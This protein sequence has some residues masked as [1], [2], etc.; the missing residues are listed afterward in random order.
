M[1]SAPAEFDNPRAANQAVT[2]KVSLSS[3]TRA[4]P[5]TQILPCRG[6]DRPGGPPRPHTDRLA[7][8]RFNS[9]QRRNG[10]IFLRVRRSDQTRSPF[11]VHEPEGRSQRMHDLQDFLAP[12][13]PR[14]LQP[15]RDIA[16]P[17]PM[18]AHAGAIGKKRKKVRK[19]RRRSAYFV[20]FGRGL[21][22][23]GVHLFAEERLRLHTGDH[24]EHADGVVQLVVDGTAPDDPGL[25]V[26]LLADDLRGPLRF[27]DGH[28]AAADDADQG[29]AG[30]SQVDLSEQG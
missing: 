25:W 5:R 19:K 4:V 21:H 3:S 12:K 27:G 17:G 29:A 20:H 7:R 16:V 30:V 10:R 22:R 2:Y 11:E 13:G 26:D 9:I 18:G 8:H 14:A 28:V 24:E 6:P 1:P 15:E 23:T